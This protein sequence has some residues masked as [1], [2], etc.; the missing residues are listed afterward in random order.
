MIDRNKHYLSEM[1]IEQWALI[2]PDRLHGVKVQSV[3]IPKSCQVLFVS[4]EK[5]QQ[6]LAEMLEKVL[7]SFDVPLANAFHLDPSYYNGLDC[8]GVE[9]VWFA[10]C[11]VDTSFSGRLLASPLLSE[12]MEN[13]HHKR[14]LWQQIQSQ[15]S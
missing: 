9:W 3:V 1:G 11:E 5:P 2:H 8:S 15:T 7:S 10:G 4:P 14:A 12:V 13:T 6:A